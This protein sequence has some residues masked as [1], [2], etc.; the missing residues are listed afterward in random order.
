[1]R[2]EFEGQQYELL[3]G[4]DVPNDGTYLELA[5]AADRKSGASL[6]V[7]RSD[8]DGRMT[9]SARCK[10]LPLA[11]VEWFI[12]EAKRRLTDR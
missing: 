5:E 6:C 9:F 1:M 11:A 4:S 3:L 12:A 2:V 7:F 8:A 10:D